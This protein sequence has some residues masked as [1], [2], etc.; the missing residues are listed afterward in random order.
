MRGRLIALEGVDGCGKSTQA[1]RLAEA[2]GAVLTREPGA[3]SLGGV[4]RSLMLNH[5][6]VKPDPVP[7]ANALMMMADRAQH[8]AEVIRPAIEAGQWVVTDRYSA[9]TIAYQG[10]GLEIELDELQKVIDFA[11]E[12]F[13][14]DLYIYLTVEPEEVAIRLRSVAPD[15]FESL[16]AEFFE[17]VRSGYEAQA[18]GPQWARVSGSGSPDDVAS[19]VL[20]VVTSKLGTPGTT[21]CWDVWQVRSPSANAYCDKL[22]DC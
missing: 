17:R 4:L 13:E 12:G 22:A 15:R 21:G 5:D 2:I 3:T 9:S 8:I 7:R 20:D 16:G 14:P 6:Q 19:R 1:K 10:Y 11:T 18:S